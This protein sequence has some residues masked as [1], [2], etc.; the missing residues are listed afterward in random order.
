MRTLLATNGSVMFKVLPVAIS[1]AIIAAI[2]NIVYI[3]AEQEMWKPKIEDPWAMNMVGSAI[4]FAIVYRTT[5]AWSRYWEASQ[6]TSVMFSKW[7]ESYCQIMNFMNTTEKDL[8]QLVADG[9]FDIQPKLMELCRMRHSLAHY[10]S[11]LA[12]L[13]SHRLTHGDISRMRRRAEQF[14][15]RSWKSF[16][17]SLCKH[18]DEL[19]VASE[20]LRTDDLTNAFVMPIFRV[21]TLRHSRS[22]VR[23]KMKK[24]R[25][26]SPSFRGATKLLRSVTTRK[27]ATVVGQ[28]KKA[29]SLPDR[30][31]SEVTDFTA[32]SSAHIERMGSTS[33]NVTWNSDLPILGS[34]TLEE[35]DVLEGSSM[36]RTSSIQGG[37]SALDRPQMVQTWIA[38]EI[39]DLVVIC[40]MPAPIMSRSYQELSNGMNGY[41]QAQKIADIPFPFPFT[42][43]MEILLYG[44]SVLI[45]MHTAV[46]TQ[47]QVFTPLLAFC[48]AYSLWTLSELSRELEDPFADG[49]NQLPVLDSHER[50]IELLRTNYYAH[51]P[52]RTRARDEDGTQ[53]IG[54]RISDVSSSTSINVHAT[55]SRPGEG[56]EVVHEDTDMDGN[57]VDPDPELSLDDVLSSGRPPGGESEED[58]DDNVASERAPAEEHI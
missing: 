30:R 58:S 53:S 35:R 57:K 41:S 27:F 5:M 42:Q 25:T 50:F 4:T 56:M 15:V 16:L 19:V 43:L 39:N 22:M 6:N 36:S 8:Q 48:I 9:D 14:G 51:K 38:E 12:A 13:A 31:N 20:D 18:W 47:G 1:L 33:S 26:M 2:I 7:A 37:I 44:Y 28:R 54:V 34:M 29:S 46:F 52:S 17:Q 10:F 24:K 23:A 49:P 11:L 3:P 32:T 21:Y 45:P 55:R 40:S